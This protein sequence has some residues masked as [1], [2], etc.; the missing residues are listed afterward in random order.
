MCCLSSLLHAHSALTQVPEAR[1]DTLSGQQP[2]ALHPFTVPGSLVVLVKGV[3]LDSTEYQ[4]NS[5]F[6]RLW[7]PSIA[8]NDA[9]MVRYQVWDLNLP[10]QFSRVL[11]APP[12]VDSLL[13]T[14]T[15]GPAVLV[16]PVQLRRSG[17][18]TR[19]VLTGN[20]RDATIESGLR[21]QMSGQ[22][23]PNIHLR[24]AL[25]DENTPILPEGTTQ[26][27]SELDRVF[28]EIDT[29]FGSAQLGDF[30]LNLDKSTFARLNRKIQGV[31]V[32]APLPLEAS[33]DTIHA[34]A[35]TSRGLFR[36]QDLQVRDGVQGPYRLQGNANEAFI[37]VIPGSESVYMDGIRLER[38]EFQDYVIDYATGE[39]TFTTN[40]LIKYHHRIVVEFQYRTTEFTRTLTAVE[41]VVATTERASGPPLA[42]FGV[43]FIREADGKSFDQ[44][45]GLTADDKDLLAELGDKDASR[46]GAIPVTYDPD[47]PWA[48]YMKA[49][50]TIGGQTYQIYLP[51]TD[52]SESEVYRVQFTRLGAG[53][54]DY[55]RQGQ[56][57]NGIIYSYRGPGQGEY[58]P[59]RVLPKPQQQRMFDLRGSFAPIRHVEI[60]GEW[61][62]SY[63]D[64]NRFSSLDADDDRAHSYHVQ[65]KLHDL[66]VGLGKTEF[67]LNRRRTGKNFATFSRTQPVEFTRS[68]NLP[69]DR[70]LIQMHQETI[71]EVSAAWRWSDNSS[72]TGTVGQLKQTDVFRGD[73]RESSLI[74]N[75]SYLPKLSYLLI[76]ISS[77]AESVRGQWTRHEAQASQSLFQNHVT[78]NTRLQTSQRYQRVDR[79]LR[80]DSHQYWQI[81]PS[82]ELDG[83]W[84]TWSAGFDW[85]EEHLWSNHSL[86]PGRRTATTS[87]NYETYP[88][89]GFRSQGHLG[90]RYTKHTEFFQITQGLSDERS[91]VLRWNGRTRPWGQLLRLNWF[92]EALSEQTPVLQEIY[93]RTGPEL[94]EYVWNDSN[95]NGIVEI[96]E[97]TPEVTQNEGEYART[98]IPSDSLQSVTGLKA[99]L[100]IQFEGR[101]RWRTPTAIWQKWLRHVTLRTA[102]EVQEKSTDSD[103]VNIY[104]LR[105]PRFRH[106]ENTVRGTLNLMQ[107]LWLFRNQPRYGFHA[108]CRKIRSANVFAA[109]TEMRSIDEY[110]AQIR[111]S[112]GDLWAFESDGAFSNKANT[113]TA[114]NSREFDIQT[115]SFSQ[116]IQLA[117]TSS[118]RLSSG[119]DYS[120]KSAQLRGKARILKLPLEGLWYR[121]N[122]SNVSAR[123]E[124]ASVVMTEASSSAGLALFEL[125]DGR[126]DGSSLLW[127]FNAKHQLTRV[128]RATLAYSGRSPRN[129]PVIHTV[130]MQLSA[131]F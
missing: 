57:I 88:R 110:R 38:G 5:G 129:A 51:I 101:Q 32:T 84:G 72:I 13:P 85:R 8:A 28:I 33:G 70:G 54:G 108:S 39:L 92:Y 46:S 41:A 56:T 68:W 58:N 27:L 1:I 9:A 42:S 61:A 47:T 73:R 103:P 123:F 59:V 116:E 6:N 124:F 31:G 99:R 74:V 76:D 66:P 2:F 37:L 62:H 43:T 122:Q 107:D 87:M 4:L 127:H 115:R 10:D 30:R 80:Q 119:I 11:D 7:I 26:R 126:G 83:N 112:L 111:W 86:L 24:A 14:E 15:G 97:F 81:S 36:T 35:A 45:F 118:I 49:D 82:V 98:L 79:G 63:Y 125:T 121:A 25:T 53:Q 131:V 104:L 55:V 44:E 12:P 21:L 69:I 89:E 113:S 102:I 100:N 94:G 93:I 114:F 130:R 3:V 96:D 52:A 48:H 18:I 17:S 77:D 19:G 22:L 67:E 20:N 95:G 91:L 23:S 75:E 120:R 90:L 29:P 71:D 34:A 78:I 106:P 105:Q 40:Q 109:D 60:A 128:L 50:T 16:Q 117:A 65:V 64:E